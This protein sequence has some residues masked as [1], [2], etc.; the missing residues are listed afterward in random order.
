MEVMNLHIHQVEA[1]WYLHS[2]HSPV[3]FWV[4]GNYQEGCTQDWCSQ[5][6]V[7]AKA[8]GNQ[9]VPPCVERWCETE[10]WA[11]TSFGY[12][13]ST[14]SLPVR[15]HC[16]NARWIRCQADLNSF[17]LENRRRPPGCPRTTWMKTTQQDLKSMNL[18]LN[19]A[20]AGAQHRPL[21][22]LMSTFASLHTHS[23]AC[24]KWIPHLWFKFH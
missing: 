19:G 11:T 13:S 15:P 17:P 24:Q 1:V 10:N 18:S 20:I 23:G 12:C 5:S 2:T 4:L 22:R 7:S 16:A 6:V 9:M 8:A 3:R 14:A 21:W